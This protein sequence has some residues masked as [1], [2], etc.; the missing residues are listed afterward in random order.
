MDKLQVSA[1]RRNGIDILCIN[2]TRV[3]FVKFIC[4]I[5]FVIRPKYTY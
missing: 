4:L 1:C 3:Y 5:K 2:E